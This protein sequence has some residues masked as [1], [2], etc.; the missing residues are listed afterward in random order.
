MSPHLPVLSGQEVIAVLHQH[1]FLSVRQSGSHV[2]L[3]HPDGRRTTVP[4]HGGRALGRGL[5]RQI[6]R[7]TNLSVDDPRK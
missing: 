1:G 2:V 7:D 3:R 5:L 6:M 4:V